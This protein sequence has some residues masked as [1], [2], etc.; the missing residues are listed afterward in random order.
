GIDNK[1]IRKKDVS[2]ISDLFVNLFSLT[3]KD[4][5]FEKLNEV[6]S[7][8]GDE[9]RKITT[10]HSS[11]LCALLFFYNVTKEHPIKLSINGK[12][13]SFEEVYFEF[14][15]NCIDGRKP[16]N[17]DVVLISSDGETLLFLES[18]FSEYVISYS[19][20]L[21]IAS[22][23]RNLELCP[24]G[25]KL[26]TPKNVKKIFGEK[27]IILENDRTSFK[28]KTS[29]NMYIEGIKQMISHY[30]G[31]VRFSK[32]EYKDKRSEKFNPKNI[33]LG[34]ILFDNFNATEKF[35]SY[36][37]LYSKFSNTMNEIFGN[38]SVT[39]LDKPLKYSEYV[40]VNSDKI[41]TKVREFYFG[42][43]NN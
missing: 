24:I 6:C 7:G 19:K 16:S 17:I 32:K 10:I 13:V 35:V 42:N 15:N 22:D 1:D 26:Y 28:I 14:Q 21:K 27:S 43:N 30:I 40:S 36:E 33:Y 18:K 12:I 39:L 34:T 4:I 5:F 37:T 20:T 25:E 29:V 31:A 38:S 41:D 9:A 2:K 23:Y 3:N 8:S 11:S